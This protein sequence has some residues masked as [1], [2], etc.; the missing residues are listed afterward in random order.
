MRSFQTIQNKLNQKIQALRSQPYHK[1][2][3]IMQVCLMVIIC[4]LFLGW[5]FSVKNN[6]AENPVI[7]KTQEAIKEETE[8]PNRLTIFQKGIELVYQDYLRP[9]FG[10]VGQIL[11]GAFSQFIGLVIDIAQPISYG[12]NQLITQYKAYV[13]LVLSLVK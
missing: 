8:K 12:M 13:E 6:V 4:L 9:F 5:I 10:K 3:V 1:R 7:Q 11:S 2:V